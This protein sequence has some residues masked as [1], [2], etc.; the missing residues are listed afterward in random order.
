MQQKSRDRSLR[1]WFAGG[2]KS[3]AAGA[4]FAVALAAG[5]SLSACAIAQPPEG[6]SGSTAPAGGMRLSEGNARPAASP[7][8]ILDGGVQQNQTLGYYRHPALRGDTIVFVSEGDIWK[9]STAGGTATRLTAH[10]GEE[11]MPAISPDGKTLAFVASYEGPAEVYTMPMEGGL[12]VRRTWGWQR[13]GFIGWTPDNKLLYSTRQFA[14]LPSSQT[15]VLDLNTGATSMVELYEAD[16]GSFSGDGKTFFF[17][18]LPFQGSHTKRYKGGFIQ[19]LWK[20]VP[21]AGDATPLTTD[22][23]G[24]SKDAMWFEGRVYFLSDRDGV[25]NLWSMNEDGKDLK[26]HTF[27]KEFDAAN[28]EMDS[29][30]VVYSHKGDVHVVDVKTN[31]DR[32]VN[33]T[34]TSDLDQLRE[35]WVKEPVRAISSVSVS[36]NGDRVAIVSRGRVFVA[37]AKARHGRFVELM[38]T[39]GVRGRSA[40]FTP[41]GQRV[42]FASDRSG[43]VEYWSLPA[44]GAREAGDEKMITSDGEILRWEAVISPDGKLMAHSDKNQKLYITEIAT[45]QTTKVFDSP[46]D[47]PSDYSWSPDSQWLVFQAQASNMAQQIQLYSLKDKTVTPIS[48]DRFE[49]FSPAFSPDGKWLYFL[50][51]RN[52]RSTV[53]SPWGPMAPQPYFDERTK[54]YALALKA[55]E[56]SP[57]QAKDELFEASKEKDKEKDKDKDKEKDKKPEPAPEEGKDV[58]QPPTE[59]AKEPAKE[60]SKEPVKPEEA[61]KAKDGKDAKDAKEA[62]DAGK[63]GK[64]AKKVTPVVIE[65]EGLADRLI[66]VPIAPGNYSRLSV[67]EGALYFGATGGVSERGDGGFTLKGVA[68]SNDKVEVKNVA[69]GLRAYELSADKKKIMLYTGDSISIVDAAPAPAEVEKGRVSL[70]AWSM[71]YSPMAEYRQLYTDAWRLLRD[72]FYA[73]NMHGVDWNAMRTKYAPLV[74]RIRSRAELNDILA[75][76]TGELSTLHHFVRGGDF[77]EGPDN[78]AISYLGCEFT[79]DEKQGGWVISRIYKHDPDEPNKAGPLMRPGIDVKEGDVLTAINGRSTLDVPHPAALLRAKANQQVLITVKRNAGEAKDFIV[80]PVNGGV[81]ADLRYTDWE[82]SRRREVEKLGEGKIG[83]VHL[84][85]MGTEN[86][87]EWARGYFPVYNREGLIIDVRRNNGGNID[88]WILGQLLRKAW[89]YWNQRVGVA[90]SWNM[91][92]AFRGHVVVICD[93]FTASD[94]EAFSDG[95]RRLGIGK[96]IGTRTWGGEVWLSSSNDLSDGGLASAGEFGVFNLDGIWLVEGHGVD[97]DIVVD[98]PPHAAF[99]G[100]D[101]QLKAAVEHLKKLMKEKPVPPVVTPALPDKSVKSGPGKNAK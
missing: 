1:R 98:N 86:I 45:G 7:A 96:V 15:V 4:A 43:E 53:P 92:Y 10:A 6:G 62:K 100:E 13:G 67:T 9:V 37:P 19:Q 40:I 75:Q 24:T 61:D 34:L 101:A 51:D 25:M 48:S 72:Y 38:T 56:R 30:R 64:D 66:E 63:D 12:P 68:I 71:S 87:S 49:S 79:R 42:V 91:Q 2:T 76:L 28:P 59:P 32:V 50:S 23:A 27:H 39:P 55:G 14:T 33:I 95:F 80:R 16:Q 85:A 26:Q 57:W 20:F 88:S 11:S 65:M 29:G 97:P 82:F 83:Y 18:R 74:E 36:P 46:V 84:R 94:G 78:V 31:A 93:S 70:D 44:R 35:R 69:S 99:K 89:M 90:P 41:D 47:R 54:V 58:K 52:I 60:P 81:Q 21:G 17:T 22:Y 3:G 73:T 8:S 5:L 77:R